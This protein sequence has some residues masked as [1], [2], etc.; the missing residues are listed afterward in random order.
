[1]ILRPRL[2][3]YEIVEEFLELDNGEWTTCFVRK[4]KGDASPEHS[5]LLGSEL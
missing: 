4:P 1:M 2:G 5:P 3:G